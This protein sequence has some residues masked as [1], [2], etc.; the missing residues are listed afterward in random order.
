[1]KLPALPLLCVLA[2]ASGLSHPAQ[3]DPLGDTPAAL[4]PLAVSPRATAGQAATHVLWTNTDGRLS[5]W[6]YADSGA[7]SQITYG[8]YAGWT[9]KAVADGPDGR[10]RVLWTNTSGAV[11]LWSLDNTTGQFTQNT[12]GPYAGWSASALSVTP[13]VGGALTGAAGGDLTGTCPN[14]TVAANAIDHTKLA[15]DAASLSQVSGGNL[16]ANPSDTTVNGILH[17][18]DHLFVTNWGNFGGGI[19]TQ[20]IELNGVSPANNGGLGRALVNDG[21][22]GLVINQGNDFGKVVVPSDFVATG[23]IYANV[24]VISQGGVVANGVIQ[25]GGNIFSGL[26]ILSAGDIHAGGNFTTNNTVSAGSLQ[27]TGG[28]DLAEPYK[29]A[30]SAQVQPAP[31]LV[32]SID[33]AH[34]GQMRVCTRAYDAAVGGIISGANGIQPGITLRQTGTVADGTLPI[35]S[36]GRVW[37]W[38]DAGAGGAISPGD[39]LTT[40]DTPGHAMRAADH[41]RAQGAIIGKAMSP[42]ASGKGLVLVLVS[43]Q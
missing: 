33:P 35:A 27:L 39:L 11:S 1:M 5:L 19:S 42:L 43:L 16:T 36:A 15:S 37:C 26:G 4:V 3:A 32:V 18:T 7:F 30:A 9:A 14:P 20:F 34:T 29:I 8:P 6:N 31:G 41:A 24:N 17:I 2:C 38:C 10:Q 25:S 21:A 22:N 13:A 40:S 23:T 28:S 12:Y